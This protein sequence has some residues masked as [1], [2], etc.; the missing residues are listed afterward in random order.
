MQVSAG[1]IAMLGG[2]IFL[3]LVGLALNHSLAGIGLGIPV[4]VASLFVR[5]PI[6][7]GRTKLG[8]AAVAVV[9]LVAV[10]AMFAGPM[11]NNLTASGADRLSSSRY[12]SFSNGL[13]AASDH[14]PVGSGFG[15]F[16]SVYPSYENPAMVDR[17][18]I[19]HVHNDYIE[20]A[21]EAGAAGIVLMVAFLLWWAIRAIAVWRAPT[22][23]AF[24]RAATI[25]SAAMLA[26]SVV[27]FPLRTSALAAVFAMCISLMAGPRRRLGVEAADTG[28]EPTGH[29]PRHLS[30]G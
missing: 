24:G 4:L 10:A 17:W 18:Y 20:L 11:E 21:L 29:G 9:M 25:A 28:V 2:A 27:D 6:Q 5:A 7:Q 13:R 12:T 22:I 3:L 19:N 30:I 15:T 23:D 26:H 14:F 1:K 8:L 16:A